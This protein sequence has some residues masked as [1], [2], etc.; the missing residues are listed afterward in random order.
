MIK[1]IVLL[2]FASG[3]LFAQT[4][5]ESTMIKKTVNV[6]VADDMAN[7]A[8]IKEYRVKENVY[9]YDLAI[10]ETDS[11][12]NSTQVIIAQNVYSI[13]KDAPFTLTEEEE[14]QLGGGG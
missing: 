5:T 13:K 11:L 3:L 6:Q 14:T 10:T 12:S 7:V 4:E 9:V 1:L 8:I 2:M